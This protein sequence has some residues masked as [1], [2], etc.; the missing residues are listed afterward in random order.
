MTKGKRKARKA[1]AKKTKA[2]KPK[3][4]RKAPKAKRAPPAKKAAVKRKAKKAPKVA[5][6]AKR[7][8]GRPSI[9]GR[10]INFKVSDSDLHRAKVNAK[11]HSEGN[12]SAWVREAIVHYSP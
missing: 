2:Q 9:G 3:K 12:L 8:G 1:A 4:A 6:K 7:R 10:L 11:K 5:V